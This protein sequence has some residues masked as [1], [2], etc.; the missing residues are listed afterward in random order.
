MPLTDEQKDAIAAGAVIIGG[1]GLAYSLYKVF[2]APTKKNPNVPVTRPSPILPITG[3]NLPPGPGLPVGI[4]AV[5]YSTTFTQY[6]GFYYTSPNVLA[7]E[8]LINPLVSLS[9]PPYTT[10]FVV[11]IITFRVVDASG[12]GVPNVPVTC[13]GNL[14]GDDQHGQINIDGAVATVYQPVTKN[15]DANGEV[16]FA[17]R[18]V[19]TDPRFLCGL[20]DVGCCIQILFA[21]IR[22]RNICVGDICDIPSF[23]CYA[24]KKVSTQSR[25]Y[26]I[27]A[28]ISGTVKQTAI[29][30]ACHFESQMLW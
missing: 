25:I 9:G 17:L 18:Y 22:S 14:A 21:S 10:G 8:L 24:N 15:T 12:N 26:T 29:S 13:Y 20:H 27:T 23:I 30:V 3:P 4:E 5:V 6:Y 11:Q 1:A 7:R 2:A 28:E 19:N 16:S